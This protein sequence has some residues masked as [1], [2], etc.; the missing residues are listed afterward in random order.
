MTAAKAHTVDE[1]G[2]VV[3]FKYRTANKIPN[4]PIAFDLENPDF[5]FVRKNYFDK[6]F[7]R[8]PLKESVFAHVDKQALI[9]MCYLYIQMEMKGPPKGTPH[10]KAQLEI[11]TKMLRAMESLNDVFI[12]YDTD[13][14]FLHIIDYNFVP[15]FYLK[16]Q[17]E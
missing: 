10:T 11:Y 5:L 15:D 4:L 1:V 9:S 13:E 7:T 8:I 17:I 12:G 3:V 14:N 16:F 2:K 6:I